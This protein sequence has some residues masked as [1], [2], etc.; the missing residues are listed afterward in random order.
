MHKELAKVAQE[1]VIK[2][3]VVN[4]KAFI[5]LKVSGIEIPTYSGTEEGSFLPSVLLNNED[6]YFA[7]DV[8]MT[9]W[10]ERRKEEYRL[11]FT[12]F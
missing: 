3:N 11:F 8:L 12:Q 6:P 10:V 9:K 7:V 5:N 2:E 1:F 4:E